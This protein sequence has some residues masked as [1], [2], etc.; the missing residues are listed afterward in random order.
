[1]D[2]SPI[3][4]SAEREADA[5]FAAALPNQI[6]DESIDPDDGEAKRNGCK[7][8]EDEHRETAAREGAVEAVLH[9]AHVVEREI[10]I[11]F[12]N[13]PL[14]CAGEGEGIPPGSHD[15]THST[16]DVLGLREIKGYARVRI[17]SV[18]FD[19]ADDADNCDPWRVGLVDAAHMQTFADGVMVWPEL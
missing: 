15:H 18:L 4:C 1:M 2:S 10:R 14:D 6:G 3:W 13:L 5:H 7:G 17:E 12:A 8:P 11:N 9:G 19:A 16:R